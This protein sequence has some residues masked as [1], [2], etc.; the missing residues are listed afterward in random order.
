MPERLRQLK[1]SKVLTPE[2]LE[3]LNFNFWTIEQA[4]NAVGS[5]PLPPPSPPPTGI[6]VLSVH[7]AEY[8]TDRIRSRTIPIGAWENNS[9][10]NTGSEPNVSSYIGMGAS[11][12]ITRAHV[13]FKVPEDY[14]T[15]GAL[16]ILYAQSGTSLA[17][18]FD[19]TVYTKKLVDNTTLIDAAYDNADGGAAPAI[20]V[21][22]KFRIYNIPITTSLS[23][24]DYLRLTIER[25][26]SIDTNPDEF[27]FLG[28]DFEYEADM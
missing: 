24:G 12:A 26:S 23:A 11:G 19:V 21:L 16:N 25:N 8:H 7:G 6:V 28:S 27:R 13:I 5:F 15:S 4:L 18:D 9:K 14:K 20:G 17:G 2:E 3:L 22:N 10:T 1:A